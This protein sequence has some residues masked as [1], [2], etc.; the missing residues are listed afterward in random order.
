MVFDEKQ[1]CSLNMLKAKWVFRFALKFRITIKIV[2]M[3]HSGEYL[4]AVFPLRIISL[5]QFDKIWT[6]LEGHWAKISSFCWK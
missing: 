5:G 3:G 4:H 2:G 6:I 1:T